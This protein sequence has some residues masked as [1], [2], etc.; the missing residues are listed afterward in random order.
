M[1]ETKPILEKAME[2][3]KI[4]DFGIQGKLRIKMYQEL[5]RIRFLKNV[6]DINRVRDS[7]ILIKLVLGEDSVN[8]ISA[9][10]P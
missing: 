2:V 4:I 3:G 1:Q 7:I 8:F 5:L 10:A 6:V 9:C